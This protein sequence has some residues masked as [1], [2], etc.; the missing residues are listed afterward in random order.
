MQIQSNTYPFSFSK[1]Y[2]VHLARLLALFLVSCLMISCGF[3]QSLQQDKSNGATA[4]R[5]NNTSAKAENQQKNPQFLNHI[6]IDQEQAVT[7][8]R[9]QALK[10]EKKTTG[11]MGSSIESLSPLLF[12]YAILMDVPVEEISEEAGLQFIEEWY[13]TPYR[14]GGTTKSGIDCSA[15]TLYFAA[16]VY[17]LSLPRTSR[18][19]YAATLPLAREQL[20]TGDLV[21]FATRKG[22]PISHVGIYLRNNKFVHASTSSGVMISDLDEAYWKPK[23]VGG[24][25]MNG[26]SSGK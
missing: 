16:N 15:F 7:T 18:E 11:T 17:G 1:F 10:S 12:K 24:G 26:I 2:G 25:R 14:L 5:S 20:Q 4:K 9:L 8:Q 13:G 21:F 6:T 23:F 3:V 19:Q 22:R